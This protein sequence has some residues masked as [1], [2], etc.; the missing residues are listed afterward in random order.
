MVDENTLNKLRPIFMALKGLRSDAP[1]GTGIYRMGNGR[2]IAENFNDLIDELITID[3][4]ANY[5]KY[6]V[7]I[8]V[9]SYDGS[10]YM[11]KVQYKSNISALLMTLHGKYFYETESE[12]FS[13]APSNITYQTQNQTQSQSIDVTVLLNLQE[14]LNTKLSDN[15]YNKEEKSF[16][17]TVKTKLTS[18]K[19]FGDL[20]NLIFLTAQ[21]YGITIER[22]I[23]I[24]KGLPF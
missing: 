16:I 6:T 14:Y 20:I 11:D 22:M 13:G 18:V 2:H 21:T 5:K 1:D 19:K 10:K 23:Q 9:D 17:E 24:F 7:D 15:S 12:P 4:T 8:T 3:N